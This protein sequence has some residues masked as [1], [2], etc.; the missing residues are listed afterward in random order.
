[1]R[2]FR[3]RSVYDV[4]AL[5]SFFLVLCGGT[6]LASVVISS[7][8]QV[9]AG[10]ISGHRPPTGNHTN[11]IAGSVGTS[12]LADGLVNSSKL[13]GHAVRAP[14]LGPV[15]VVRHT[16]T[17]AARQHGSAIARCPAGARLIGGGA[18][19]NAGQNL[20]GSFPFGDNGWGIN[21]RNDTAGATITITAYALCLD[22]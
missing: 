19:D 11:I 17:V 13:A 22:G 9:G 1:M 4:L 2:R 8:S 12:D 21:Y 14:A 3:P 10:T 7:N 20:T 18:N 5:M 6:A 15:T 16:A